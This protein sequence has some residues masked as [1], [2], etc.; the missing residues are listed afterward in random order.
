[1]GS[2]PGDSQRRYMASA[3]Q[4]VWGP[5]KAGNGPFFGVRA[6]V[7]TKQRG[8]KSVGGRRWRNHGEKVG[9]IP[10]LWQFYGVLWDDRAILGMYIRIV[11]Q[12][13]PLKLSVFLQKTDL[14]G[15][16]WLFVGLSQAIAS[17]AEETYRVTAPMMIPPIPLQGPVNLHN[18]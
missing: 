14:F 17:Q 9:R 11:F 2:Y 1:M 8:I 18:R 15:L 12:N 4:M 3:A 7:F 5:G 6:S 16:F 10:F 13:K